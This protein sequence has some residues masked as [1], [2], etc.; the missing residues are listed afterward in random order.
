MPLQKSAAVLLD[1]LKR[2]IG[3]LEQL[4][5][6]IAVY[7][8]VEHLKKLEVT[9]TAAQQAREAQ[10]DALQL[11]RALRDE[12]CLIDENEAMRRLKVS[13]STIKRMRAD[14]RL[15]F[16]RVGTGEKLVRYRP[17]DVAAIIC[18]ST[19]RGVMDKTD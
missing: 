8:R 5:A 6:A 12:E 15:P 13:E 10:V 14:G 7:E 1:E 9:L 16:V 3:V 17:S 19:P 2:Q 18:R 4:N 11:V